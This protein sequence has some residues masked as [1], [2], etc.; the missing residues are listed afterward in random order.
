[1]GKCKLKGVF[2]PMITPF[3]EDGSVD[4]DGFAYNIEKW[5]GTGLAGYLV[6]GSNSETPFL[7]EEEKTELIRLTVECAGSVQGGYRHRYGSYGI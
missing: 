2:P 3:K 6:L 1:M 4:Y 5:N 7:N